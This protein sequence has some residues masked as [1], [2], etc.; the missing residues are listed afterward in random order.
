LTFWKIRIYIKPKIWR[1]FSMAVISSTGSFL[2]GFN[3]SLAGFCYPLEVWGGGANFSSSLPQVGLWGKY[4]DIL[5]VKGQKLKARN[6][7][8]FLVFYL[9]KSILPK[10]SIYVLETF[11]NF[12]SFGTMH[13]KLPS[14]L[15]FSKNN[16]FSKMTAFSK[17]KRFIY[18]GTL[19]VY[20]GRKINTDFWGLF[21]SKHYYTQISPK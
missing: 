21:H 17:K 9:M 8:I 7:F 19:K 20:P 14:L 5:N 2:K 1:F 13:L 6:F 15:V 11:W 18:Q 12:L 4:F 10:F 16:F 3:H